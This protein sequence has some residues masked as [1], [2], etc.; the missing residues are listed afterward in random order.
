MMCL[1]T[2]GFQASLSVF[3]YFQ[4]DP[5]GPMATWTAQTRC[6]G[7]QDWTLS[8]IKGWIH[9]V[10]YYYFFFFPEDVFC[11][12]KNPSSYESSK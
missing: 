7:F 1:F 11:I 6:V 5:C 2:P 12:K 10:I 9:S 3:N 8:V 4:G